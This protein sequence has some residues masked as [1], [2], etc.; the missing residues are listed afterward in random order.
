LRRHVVIDAI[1]RG[2]AAH[3]LAEDRD[4]FRVDEV[5]RCKVT[6]GGVG[7]ERLGGADAAPAGVCETAWAKAVDGECD[8]AR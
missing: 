6:E 3:R 7:V 1:E 4:P 5:L 2:N 8:I